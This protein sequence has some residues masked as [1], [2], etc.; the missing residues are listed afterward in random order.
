M[1]PETCYRQLNYRDRQTIAISLEQ[2]LSMRA[3]ARVLN[4]S[5]ATI[6]PEIARN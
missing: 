4:R 6:S 2:G 5:A 1:K 3:T